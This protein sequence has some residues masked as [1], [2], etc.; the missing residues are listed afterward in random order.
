LL[1]DLVRFLSLPLN[2]TCSVGT[3]CLKGVGYDGATH[4]S[5]SYLYG[6]KD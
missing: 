3:S 6:A 4:G 1:L 2:F 5:F